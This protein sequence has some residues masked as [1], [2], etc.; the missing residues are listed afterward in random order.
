MLWIAPLAAQHIR[1]LGYVNPYLCEDGPLFREAQHAGYL[2]TQSNG[3]VYRVD[4][5]EFI[6]GMVDFSLPAAA[7]WF[8]VRVLHTEMLSKGLSGW[9]ADFGEYQ[10]PD[11]V[12]NGGDG[13]Q[14]HN[15]LP[16]LWARSNARAIERAGKTG[17]ALFFMRSGYTGSQRYCSLMWAGDQSVDFSRH[18]GLPSVISAALSAG[19]VG[20]PYHHSDIGGYTSLFGN[21]RSP[22]LF[23]R[24]AEL[25]AFTAVMRTHEGNRPD[26]NVQ[27]WHSPEVLAHF[28]RMTQLYAALKPYRMQCVKDAETHG[29]PLQRPLFF[30]FENDLRT[31]ALQDCFLLGAD[32][33]VAPVLENLV[34]VRHTYLPQGERWVHLWTRQ[35][36]EGGQHVTVAAPLGSPPVFVREKSEWL[37]TLLTVPQQLGRAL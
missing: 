29:W 32:L 1:F 30:H 23:Q 14:Q 28:A 37:D 15:L 35:T 17:E 16:V 8:E 6:C 22:E 34:R 31:W 4:F 25:A 12:V 7:E 19:L 20:F 36:F 5:G 21:V 33:L 27:F 9:M 13:W 26:D 11:A 18:D 10:P 3:D 24:W 2:I